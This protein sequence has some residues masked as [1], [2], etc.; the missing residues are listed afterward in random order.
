[1]P[2]LLVEAGC[3]GVADVCPVFL[4]TRQVADP[5]HLHPQPERK[6]V[7]MQRKMDLLERAHGLLCNAP[8]DNTGAEEGDAWRRLRT[9]WIARYGHLI[10]DQ[11]AKE[12]NR[13]V[14]IG[15][16]AIEEY[17]SRQPKPLTWG[18]IEVEPDSADIR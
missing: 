16:N 2:E 14:A 10:K 11:Q 12:H 6:R 15:N 5:L 9:E 18:G 1:V 17:E 4:P 8:S 7:I 13:R 3:G